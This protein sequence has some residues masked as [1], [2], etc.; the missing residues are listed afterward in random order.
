MWFFSRMCRAFQASMMGL[1]LSTYSGR[2]PVWGLMHSGDIFEL[3]ILERPTA[4]N[5]GFAWPTPAAGDTTGGGSKSEGEKALAGQ[6]RASGAVRQKKLRD[7]ALVNWSTPAANETALE[8]RGKHGTHITTKNGTIRRVN[9]DGTQS[10]LGLSAQ[11]AGH[12]N[13]DWVETLMGFP[14]GWTRTA[15]LPAPA[16]LSTSTS[17]RV[18]RVK[19]AHGRRDSRRLGTRLCRKSCIRFSSASMNF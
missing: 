1:S 16:N 14:V 3:Q 6:K 4:A 18:L 5:A 12:L 19:K 17:R 13:P 7:V 15:G 11:V 9:A 2:L 8:R 10:N